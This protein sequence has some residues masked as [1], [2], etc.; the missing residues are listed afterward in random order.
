MYNYKLLYTCN[1]I[2]HIHI[3]YNVKLNIHIFKQKERR[4]EKI[5]VLYLLY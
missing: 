4:W 2:L 1:N 3:I 5:V